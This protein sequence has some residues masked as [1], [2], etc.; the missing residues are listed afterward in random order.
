VSSVTSAFTLLPFL[1]CSTGIK[2]QKS[3]IL[4][5]FFYDFR[6]TTCGCEVFFVWRYKN[7][8]IYPGRAPV[9]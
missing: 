6:I 1:S 2:H 5:V 4:D 9:R 7:R 3:Y 8:S